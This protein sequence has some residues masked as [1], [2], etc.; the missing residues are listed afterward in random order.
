MPEQNMTL[1]DAISAFKNG[2]LGTAVTFLEEYTREHQDNYEAFV[3]MGAVYSKQKRLNA[4]IGSFKKA[5]EIKPKSPVIHY[6]LAQAYELAGVP[7]EA[8]HEYKKALE[9]NPDY[10]RAK[11]AMNSLSVKLPE[12]LGNTIEFDT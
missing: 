2:D 7:E 1:E 4:A 3:Y 8:W 9:L 11:Q 12:L 10:P 6:N 5:S